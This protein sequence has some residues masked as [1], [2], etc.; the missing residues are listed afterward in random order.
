MSSDDF[1]LSETH[2]QY[3]N[4]HAITDATID[5]MDIHSRDNEIVFPWRDG[6]L[7]TEQRRPWPGESGTYYWEKG[8]DLHFWHMTPN[9]GNRP[10]LLVEG[11]K[12]SLAAFSYAGHAY[13]VLGM[14]GCEGWNK[15]DLSRFENRTV[16]LCLDADAGSNLAVY[17][18]G[19]M[20]GRSAEFYDAD[21]KYLQLPARGSAGLDDCLAKVAPDKRAEYIER[22]VRKAGSK[23]AEKRP[24]SRKGPKMGSDIPDVGDR[25]GVAVNLDRKEVIDK[26]TDAFKERWD[27][28]TLFNYGDILTRI[29]GHETQPLDRDSFLAMLVDTVACFKHHPA[30]EKRPAVF[31]PAWPDPPSIGAVMS[32]ADQFV[33]LR[34]VVRVPF[35]RPD[36]TVCASPGYDAATA[37]VL[38]PSGIDDVSVPA[39]P[40]QEETRAAAKLL[41][42]EWL[43][44]LPFKTDADRA[45]ALALVL[46]PF[47]RGTVPLVPLAVV[48]GL[49]MGVGKNLFA[50]CLGL[51]TT[52]EPTMPLPYVGQEEEMRKQ[53]TAAFSSGADIFVFDEAHVVEGAQLARAVTSITYGD[54]VLGVSRIAKFPNQVTWVSLGNQVQVNGDMSRRVYFIYLHP[55][56]RDVMDREAGAFRHPDLK[57]WTAENRTALVSAALTVLRGWHAAGRPAFSRGACMGSFEPWDRLMS[58]VLAYA[59]YPAFLG[60]MKERRSESDFT[61]AYWSAH[62][63]W[64]AGEFGREEFTTAQVR[65]RAQRDPLGFEAPPG[66]EDTSGRDYNRQLGMAY[67]KH[68]DRNYDGKR[69][70][71]SG[72]GHKSTIKWCVVPDDGGTEVG[73]GKAPTL[74]VTGEPV[75]GDV[76]VSTH[77][78]EKAARPASTSLRTSEPERERLF[79]P[80]A[81]AYYA[82]VL[83]LKGAKDPD[84]PALPVRQH[85]TVETT[86]ADPAELETLERLKD[87]LRAMP[88]DVDSAVEMGRI[89]LDIHAAGPVEHGEP[90]GDALGFDIETHSASKLWLTKPDPSYVKLVGGV[91]GLEDFTVCNDPSALVDDLNRAETI[92]G[93]NILAFDL[94]ALARHCGADYDALAAKA[95]DTLVLARLAD[96]PMA[97]DT[98]SA[99]KYDLDTVAKELGHT[100]KSDDLKALAIEYG[101]AAGLTGKEAETEGYGL[102]DESDP[103]Y[104]DY[105]RGDLAASQH[106]YQA[107]SVNG[108]DQ[109]S[110]Y[111]RRE[112]KVVALQNRMTLNGWRV[113]R[114]ELARRVA[115]EDAHRAHAVS[116]LATRYG[117]PTEKITH[118]L[119]WKPKAE[120]YGPPAD[121]SMAEARKCQA[122]DPSWAVEWDVGEWI[123]K[124]ETYAAPWAT[125]AGRAAL[126]KAFKAAGAEFYPKTASGQLALSSDALGEGDWYDKQARKSKPGMLK[127]YG[128]L[129]EVRELCALVTEATGA[130]AKYAEIQKY[131]NAD[132]RVHPEVGAAQASGRWGNVRFASS[133]MGKRGEKVEQRAVLLPD[134]DHVL[135][136]CDMSQVDMR[137]IAGLCQDP[138]YMALFEPG[139][140]AHS[141]MAQVYFGEVTK[142][143]RH[144]TKAINH[145]VNYGGSAESTAEMNSLPLELVQEALRKRAEAY[146][147]LIEWTSEVRE[148]AA[149]GALL[150]NGFGRMMRP[151]PRRA[152]TQGPALMGQGAARDLMCEGL[153]RLV[154]AAPYATPYLRGVVH[155]EVILSVPEDSVDFWRE[156]LRRSFTFEWRGVPIL[157]EVSQPGRNWADCYAGE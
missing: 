122:E 41:M 65:E 75:S 90:T 58:G 94:P 92:Y 96:P 157:C 62:V 85:Q 12:Q 143:T 152:W 24:T 37:T 21:V 101:K 114:E 129:P 78:R 22:L 73:G 105:L 142:E 70:V 140:D 127:V 1:S 53:L 137:G 138:A 51:L 56:G 134:E 123:E 67:S 3:L 35:L 64:L 11:T 50:D 112:M 120:W 4:D 100:G 136:A 113:D 115:A 93:H 82:D 124:R 63:H 48:S 103:R 57:L 49:Q 106:I 154:E 149:S 76:C 71:K 102:I 9:G 80:G 74:H 30:T 119:K 61:A 39:E 33:P 60:D 59:G 5:G 77:V 7:V 145:K 66:M 26:I 27:G 8:K 23:P 91:G 104:R 135:L 47:I 109:L 155:D 88:V 72:M 6:D 69:L 95:V 83:G 146:P 147:R 117:L 29:R 15:C 43:G 25:V 131:T 110:D 13:D 54:R 45:N 52:G 20:F 14:A 16:Y 81:F 10:V 87:A 108:E 98:G 36:G 2:R 153:L 111:A 128:H 133:N 28:H 17:E 31:E 38:V 46:T 121:L 132:G 42:E 34:R 144:K 139:R 19:E 141:E 18:A 126:I 118:T 79:A 148:L 86:Q 40:T 55:S 151:D 130:T 150:D 107:F 116:V 97:R 84:P 125:D 156:L 68:R 99:G 32:K 89:A 44:D